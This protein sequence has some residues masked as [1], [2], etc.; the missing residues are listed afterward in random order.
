MDHHCPWVNNCLGQENYRFFL[1]YIFYL[2]LGSGWYALTIMSIWT[3]YLYQ[4]YIEELSFLVILNSALFAVLV[5]FNLWHWFLAMSGTT[6]VE[7]WKGQASYYSKPYDFSFDMINDNLFNIFGT[8]KWVRM[9]SPSLRNIPL[10][11]I[12]WSFMVKELGLNEDCESL[13]GFDDEH[14]TFSWDKKTEVGPH[15]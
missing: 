3:H 10:N 9:F 13:V 7:F 12:E 2:M 4:Q 15:D 14:D 1:L 11:G 8:N 5:C 6:T